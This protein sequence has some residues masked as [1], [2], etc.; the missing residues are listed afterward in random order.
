M[1]LIL[2]ITS[3]R[4]ALFI[5]RLR[6]SS[7]GM[8]FHPILPPND[9]RIKNVTSSPGVGSKSGVPALSEL[10]D[11]SLCDRKLLALRNDLLKLLIRFILGLIGALVSRGESAGTG[12]LRRGDPVVLLLGLKGGRSRGD[13]GGG[14]MGGEEARDDRGT[15]EMEAEVEQEMTSSL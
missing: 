6:F 13:R 11:F 7:S 15:G 14:D 12:V 3:S 9:F 2:P 1:S 4:I 10:T 8:I 5:L